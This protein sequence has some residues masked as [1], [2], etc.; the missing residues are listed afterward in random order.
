VASE[1]RLRASEQRLRQFVADAS[2][3]LRT[4]IA[5]VSAYAELFGR[6]PRSRRRTSSG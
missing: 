6:G 1:Q 2:H 3:E 5:A 4:P